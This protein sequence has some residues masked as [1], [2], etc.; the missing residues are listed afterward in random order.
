MRLQVDALEELLDQSNVTGPVTYFLLGF[1]EFL[2]TLLGFGN[3]SARGALS[4]LFS[5]LLFPIKFLDAPF[6]GR[7]SFLGMAPTILTVVRK[8]DGQGS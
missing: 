5:V 1:I 6:I 3:D 4:L 7:R 2:S 8:P